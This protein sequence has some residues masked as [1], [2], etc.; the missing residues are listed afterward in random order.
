MLPFPGLIRHI[1]ASEMVKFDLI[2]FD[3][4]G[5]YIQVLIDIIMTDPARICPSRTVWW[6][7]VGRDPFEAI[8]SPHEAQ[9]TS[10]AHR[11]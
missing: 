8:I 5:I 3:R 4:L 7:S 11:V 2:H 6:Y 10:C 1:T 9:L